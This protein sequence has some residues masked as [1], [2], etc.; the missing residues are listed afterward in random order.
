[1]STG[2]NANHYNVSIKFK[3]E[4]KGH[5]GQGKISNINHLSNN[6]KY[7]EKYTSKDENA[8]RNI[9]KSKER[10][11]TECADPDSKDLSD[12]VQG[13][14][15]NSE[16][17]R[18]NDA[19]AFG[20]FRRLDDVVS[21][22]DE[23]KLNQ[24]YQPMVQSSINDLLASATTLDA[25]SLAAKVTHTPGMM[26][27]CTLWSGDYV[28][29]RAHVFE[30][31]AAE[32]YIHNHRQ[33]FY[34]FCVSG[35]YEHT[36]LRIDNSDPSECY[37]VRERQQGGMLSQ[38]QEALGKPVPRRVDVFS[39]RKLM[40]VPT[41]DYHTVSPVSK[42]EAQCPPEFRSKFI[43]GKPLVTITIRDKLKSPAAHI[44]SP[45]LKVQAGTTESVVT[46]DHDKGAEVVATLLG[47]MRDLMVGVAPA[48]DQ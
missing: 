2:T 35:A 43:D 36:L 18:H 8:K 29:V 13:C 41:T 11:E 38:P 9:G 47:C 19:S 15:S 5:S 7:K 20:N 48:P 14:S 21:A 34:T 31:G 28:E 10:K 45:G 22:S 4:P 39:A 24:L 25:K 17:S 16:Q 30:T 6:V 27:R 46:V 40:F 42:H 44:W 1:M 32:T 26:Y 12:G 37:Y 3:S 23:R 33:N